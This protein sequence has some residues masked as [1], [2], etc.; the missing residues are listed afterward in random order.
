MKKVSFLFYLL[1][2]A[3]CFSQIPED[4]LRFSWHPVS[5]TARVNAIGG[6]MGSL[7]GDITAT[8]VNPAGLAIYHTEEAVVSMGAAFN[9]TSA[10]Y[11][12]SIN[13]NK[14]ISNKQVPFNLG[15]MGWVFST[16]HKDNPKANSAFSLALNQ[17]INFNEKKSFAG[18]NNYS[19]FSEQFAEEFSRS[20]YSLSEVVAPNS[21]LPYTSA[22]AVSTGL[23][24]TIRSNDELFIRAAP[25]KILDR[26]QALRQDYYKRTR[27]GMYDLAFGFAHTKDDKLL[28]G[29]SM[30]IPFVTYSSLTRFSETD[31]SANRL[32][33]FSS[34]TF[35][36][37][38]S[39]NGTGLDMKLGALY[40]PT[41]QVRL[42][43][44]FHTPSYLS[45]T[46]K[47]TTRLTVEAE[48]DTGKL[49]LREA[50]SLD[51][52]NQLPGEYKYVHLTPMRV[53][54]SG[55]YVFRENTDVRKQKAFISAD[56][57]YVHYRGSRY[58]ANNEFDTDADKE[59][60]KALNR[61]IKNFYRGC[62]NF[63]FGGE[64]KFNTIMARAGFAY[65]MNPYRQRD[66]RAD[67]MIFSGGLGYRHH[68]IFIDLT[69]A[70]QTV[71]DAEFPYRL[72][73]RANTFATV[74]NQGGQISLSA[75][76]KF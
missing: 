59:Y 49:I 71:R 62:F 3:W 8:F 67:R 19:S 64:L 11:R 27:G 45:F 72:S 31:S 53:I 44:A 14:H 51:F 18:L 13:S 4:A 58:Y 26:G 22:L 17:R 10:T 6:T 40:R 50:T 9:H 68:G 73:D 5:G 32:N 36:D 76:V 63:R 47:R 54:A 39:L 37:D 61:V 16:G 38:F 48:D 30:S 1:T 69:Y 34:F 70:H 56:L 66:F 29:A 24:D 46:E 23:I 15:P 2:P 25:E 75:G 55:A 74:R 42:G 28:L 43:L 33:G 60:Y 57:E 65:Y 21:G 12:D 20:G 35:T 7:G 41:E 52:T